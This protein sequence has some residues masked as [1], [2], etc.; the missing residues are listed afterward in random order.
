MIYLTLFLTFLKIGAVSFGGGY[1]MIPLIQDEVLSH[2]WM[3]LE[4]IINFIAICESTPGP[5]A[6][7]MA[8]F[9]GFSKA[10]LLGALCATLGVV[11]PSFIIILIVVTIITNLLKFAGVKAFLDGLRPVVVGLI[12]GTAITI[13]IQVVFGIANV[14]ESTMNFDYKA[15]II[16]AVITATS[17]GY[18]KI[19]KK[20][21][22]PILLIL[23]SAVLG[24]IFYGLLV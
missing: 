22:S 6:I 7:N 14:V 19:G 10:G 18:K 21:M 8:T 20:V 4:E 13:F 17:I 15:L 9:V 1:A 11:L 23:I 5:I 3:G 2:G 16:F 24:I 12:L